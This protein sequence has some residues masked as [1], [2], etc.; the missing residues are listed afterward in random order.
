MSTKR[1]LGQMHAADHD[2]TSPSSTRMATQKA[3]S[4]QGIVI[5]IGRRHPFVMPSGRLVNDTAIFLEIGLD[6]GDLVIQ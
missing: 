6:R 1:I 5:G 2:T 3:F 4:A